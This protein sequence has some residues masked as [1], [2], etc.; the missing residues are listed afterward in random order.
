MSD[1]HERDDV[2]EA[3]HETV[4]GLHAAGIVNKRTMREFDALT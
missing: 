1:K 4:K 3:I 2:M